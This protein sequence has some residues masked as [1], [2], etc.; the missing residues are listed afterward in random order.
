MEDEQGEVDDLDDK[1][2]PKPVKTGKTSKII[3]MLYIF[4][5]LF[6]LATKKLCFTCNYT[7]I[8]I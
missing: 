5:T 6:I 1:I 3:L 8:S 4:F 7:V 2:H